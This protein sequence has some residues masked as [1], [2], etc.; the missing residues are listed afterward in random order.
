VAEP[1]FDHISF[2]G[3]NAENRAMIFFHRAAAYAIV[4]KVNHDSRVDVIFEVRHLTLRQE[5][6]SG[7]AGIRIDI[8]NC[9]GRQLEK[10]KGGSHGRD[11]HFQKA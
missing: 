5:N 4:I 1:A 11:D 9:F 10:P 6:S 3:E 8:P 2:T 7:I